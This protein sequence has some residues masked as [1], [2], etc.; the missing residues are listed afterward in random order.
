MLDVLHRM[1]EERFTA[2]THIDMVT[3]TSS[4]C[5]VAIIFN[6][7]DLKSYFQKS[8]DKEVKKKKYLIG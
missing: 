5:I 6:V 8:T 7:D 2:C 1:A 4:I 3:S